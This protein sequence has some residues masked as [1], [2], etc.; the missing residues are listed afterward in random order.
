MKK[1]FLIIMVI[2]TLYSA[3]FDC[4]KASTFIEKGICSDSE[5]SSLDEELSIYYKDA[6]TKSSTPKKLKLEQR[7]W[8]KKVRNKC[9]NIECVKNRTSKRIDELANI[10]NS[11][12]SNITGKYASNNGDLE[13]AYSEGMLFFELL[14]V[15]NK[16]RIGQVDGELTLKGNSAIY[17]KKNCSLKFLFSKKK[18][19]I[20]Q[21]G[22]CDMGLNVTATGIY[23]SMTEANAKLVIGKIGDTLS[24]LFYA[25]SEA[26][27]KKYCSAGVEENAG[28]IICEARKKTGKDSGN[29]FHIFSGE[30]NNFDGK[31][32][33]LSIAKKFKIISTN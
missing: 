10:S 17:K 25:K 26:I 22:T 32:P 2:S 27:Y 3:S 1:V 24:S 16:A 8:L 13:I 14:I 18:V 23:K 33:P 6:L 7:V 31:L 20:I 29:I 4:K 19:S 9:N 28:N 12:I 11:Y 21:K 5:A 15:T 30:Y